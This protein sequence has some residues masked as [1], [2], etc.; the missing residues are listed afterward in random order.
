[1]LWE[2][3]RGGYKREGVKWA[4]DKAFHEQRHLARGADWAATCVKTV[5]AARARFCLREQSL[6]RW[7][8][9]GRRVLFRRHSLGASCLQMCKL[10]VWPASESSI[11]ALRPLSFGPPMQK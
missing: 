8:A 10:S 11:A 3:G 6:W 9:I 1:M 2:V 5:A 4:G 7:N